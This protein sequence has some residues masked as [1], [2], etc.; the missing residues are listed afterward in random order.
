M[1]QRLRRHLTY[2]NVAATMAVVFAMSG[3]AYA[4][5]GGHAPAAG[6]NTASAN[7]AKVK[8]KSKGEAR[9]PAGPRGAA[10]PQ[11]PAGP[12]G[13]AG[14]QGE[15][16]AT[17]EKGAS[18][19]TGST[20]KEG[21][22]GPQ[23]QAGPKGAVGPAGTSVESKAFEGKA[24]TCEE[25]GSE[26]KAGTTVTYACNGKGAS[27]GGLPET[28]PAGK[29]ETGVWSVTANIEFGGTP[30][31]YTSLSFPIRLGNEEPEIEYIE[32]TTTE[33]CPGVAAEVPEAEPGYLCVYDSSSSGNPTYFH[34]W[35]SK[36]GSTLLF[37]GEPNFVARGT[38]AVTAAG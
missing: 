28:L 3:G 18:G 8:K 13:S 15:K 19:A 4:L 33:H 23:G 9:G 24:G 14:A 34:H 36:V 12:A 38:W 6:A 22:Q 30:G 21:P 27:G 16:G 1:F 32:L 26:F 11:G 10:G 25:G 17:G 37:L 5:S 35:E 2:A 31:G 20:G 29:T 7:V